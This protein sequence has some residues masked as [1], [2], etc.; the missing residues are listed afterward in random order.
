MHIIDK[1]ALGTSDL[2][3]FHFSQLLSLCESE[4]DLSGSLAG[5]MK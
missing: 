2:I 4:F 5:A 3:L 1:T